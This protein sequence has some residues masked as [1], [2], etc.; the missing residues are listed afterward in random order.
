[1]WSR[2]ADVRGTLAA[3]AK[4]AAAAPGFL[5]EGGVNKKKNDQA[6]AKGFEEFAAIEVEAVSGRSPEFVAFGFENE[7]GGL[8]IHREPVWRD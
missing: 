7:L 1:M 5:R 6:A 4:G 2:G 3:A 8:D